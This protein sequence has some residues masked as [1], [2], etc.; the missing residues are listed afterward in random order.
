MN[1]F[2]IQENENQKAR[3]QKQDKTKKKDWTK[4]P[5]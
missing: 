2:L 5:L 3:N 4:N 1:P